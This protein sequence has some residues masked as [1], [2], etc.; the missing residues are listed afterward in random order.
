MHEGVRREACAVDAC[1][2]CTRCVQCVQCKRGWGFGPR[3]AIFHYSQRPR[4]MRTG[5][6]LMATGGTCVRFHGRVVTTMRNSDWRLPVFQAPC[7]YGAMVG[8]GGEF[9]TLQSTTTRSRR[10]CSDVHQNVQFTY[11]HG[12]NVTTKRVFADNHLENAQIPRFQ[13][14][15]S[16]GGRGGAISHL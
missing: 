4:W 15:Q 9:P 3:T 16:H 5:H 1:V 10:S 7:R 14:M 11:F 6:D 2:H 8:E 13:P 12:R